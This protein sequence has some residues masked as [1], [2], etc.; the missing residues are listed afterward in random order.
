VRRCPAR[1]RDHRRLGAFRG[2]LV[3]PLFAGAQTTVAVHT[4]KPTPVAVAGRVDLSGDVPYDDFPNI[5][6]SADGIWEHLQD[7]LRITR[8]YPAPRVHFLAF[9]QK[10]QSNDWTAWQ[11]AWTRTHPAIWRDWTALRKK[12]SPQQISQAW[13]DTNID[14]IFP[15]PKTFLA[16]HYDG[17]NRIQ[18]NPARTFRL[19]VQLDPYGIRR[20]FDG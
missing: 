13:I 7:R 1:P 8:G 17:T 2:A 20:D 5:Q 9:D 3:Q 11:K 18:I 19:S 15:F 12:G 16:F 14:E 6:G 4:A 10:A